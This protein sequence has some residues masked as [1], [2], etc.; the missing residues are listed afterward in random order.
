M[1][2]Y[3]PIYSNE[4]KSI[5]S[6]LKEGKIDSNAATKK[7]AE[8]KLPLLEMSVLTKMI[9][10]LDLSHRIT[11]SDKY[12][13]NLLDIARRAYMWHID[14]LDKN[15]QS[16]SFTDFVQDI[17]KGSKKARNSYNKLSFEKK[18]QLDTLIMKIQNHL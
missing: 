13:S 10:D 15:I 6:S 17:L 2:R 4:I 7:L 18:E 3:T 11:S 14:N 1:K 12:F 5:Y 16:Y 8:L 9:M